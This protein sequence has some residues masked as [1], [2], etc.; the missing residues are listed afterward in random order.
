[1]FFIITAPYFLIYTA[2]K[3]D[4]EEL[5]LNNSTYYEVFTEINKGNTYESDKRNLAYIS[6]IGSIILTMNISIFIF[7]CIF[8]KMK[9]LLLLIILLFLNICTFV[10]DIYACNIL[11]RINSSFKEYQYTLNIKFAE[12]KDIF[13]FD[14]IGTINYGAVIYFVFNFLFSI[15]Y[16]FFIV[17]MYIAK[18]SYEKK[19]HN[20]T[21]KKIQDNKEQLNYN[22]EEEEL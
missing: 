10:I 19:H 15:Y 13:P 2:F 5:L 17:Y 4:K 21:E 8:Y 11:L 6:I 1:M 18:R 22:K 20:I 12:G 3:S 9:S 16:F 7:P 14:T